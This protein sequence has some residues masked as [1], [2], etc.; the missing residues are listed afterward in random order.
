MVTRASVGGRCCL[1]RGRDFLWVHACL[2]APRSSFTPVNV[3]GSVVWAV[4]LNSLE[5]ET[6]PVIWGHVW[7][8]SVVRHRPLDDN[9]TRSFFS[10]C[11]G[12]TGN[13]LTRSGMRLWPVAVVCGTRDSDR[14]STYESPVGSSALRSVPCRFQGDSWLF[15]H[16][17]GKGPWCRGRKR[18]GP[19]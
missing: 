19:S 4:S 11:G 7:S 2:E 13:R 12:R 16:K 15:S 14:A 9:L 18:G 5:S 8:Q 10:P 3:G 6:V 1:R 17:M